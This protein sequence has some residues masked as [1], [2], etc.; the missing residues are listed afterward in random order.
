VRPTWVRVGP[1]LSH[2]V[3]VL[4]VGWCGQPVPNRCRVSRMRLLMVSG[5]TR[6]GG[7]GDRPIVQDGG[8]EPVGEG[9]GLAPA[10]AG[11]VC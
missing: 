2:E 5:R 9:Q 1:P 4:R 3:D 7:D 6:K 10:D 11:R 8:Q